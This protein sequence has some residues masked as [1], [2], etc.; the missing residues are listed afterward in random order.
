MQKSS[1]ILAVCMFVNTVVFCPVNAEEQAGYTVTGDMRG[2]V[3]VISSLNTTKLPAGRYFF[4]FQAGTMASGQPLHVPVMVVQGAKPGRRLALTA[5]VH[6]DE[7]NGIAVIH[8][9]M[10]SVEPE[11]MS[12]TLLALPGVNQTGLVNN[13]RT[14]QSSKGGGS[15]TDPNRI[16]PGTLVSGSPAEQY[17]GAVWHGLLK[18]NADTAIDIHTQ[19]TGSIYPLFVFSDFRNKKARALAFAL[20]PD[21]IKNDTGEKGSLE[22]TYIEASIPAVTFEV[23]R[24]KV[25]QNS[26]I[27][28]AV[29]GLKNVMVLEGMLEGQ[30]QLAEPAPF[31]GSSYT[32]VQAQ[33]AGTAHLKVR[34]LDEVEKGQLIAVIVD[35]FGKEI[36]QY[37]APHGGRVLSVATD[38]L[39]EAGTMLVRILH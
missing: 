19:T 17:I 26:L 21:L 13:H 8:Q 10:R 28:R 15:Q 7:L 3:P 25:F 29:A 30:L 2:G 33:E 31:V 34:L 37:F 12:G 6:G 1:L 36:R 20:M 9:L 38:P 22:T 39:R 35:P 18:D 23:G 16:F 4:Y 11:T 24:P 5:A 14:F 32:N 27:Q